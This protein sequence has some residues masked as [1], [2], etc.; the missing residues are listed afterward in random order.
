[1]FKFYYQL[2]NMQ[3]A[4]KYLKYTLGCKITIFL[5]KSDIFLKK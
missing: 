1:M 2:N 5:E 3:L 4:N